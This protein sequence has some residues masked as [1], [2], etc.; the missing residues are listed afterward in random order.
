[1]NKSHFNRAFLLLLLIGITALFVK[2]IRPFL[3]AIFL[4]AIFAGLSAPLYRRILRLFRGRRALT[5]LATLLLLLLL[6]IIP[7]SALLGV[8]ANEAFHIAER[9][10]PWVTEQLQNPDHL[11]TRLEGIPGVRYLE[12]YRAQLLEKAGALVGTAGTFLFNGLSA[13][14]RG[15]VSFFFKFFI[16]LY[17]MFYFLMDGRSLLEKILRYVPMEEVDKQRMVD[18]FASVTR[19]TIKGTLLIGVT[20]GALSGL[21]FRIVGIDGAVFW[22]AV[23]TVLTIVP[24]IGTALVWL[25]AAIILLATGKTWQAI[26]LAGFCGLVVGNVDNLLRPRLV[27]HDTQMHSLLI[28]FGTTGG[29]MLFGV[30]GF[31]V[32]PIVAA[33]FVTIWEIYGEVFRDLLPGREP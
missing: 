18:K 23:M 17:T 4:A 6:V 10:R 30:L 9:V 20:Q 26:F 3:M 14:T 31:I 16:M 13:T 1:M 22:G 2:M 11:L 28:L 29:I 21:A 12:P 25:P 7:F 8:I 32:G 19:A 27:G 33:L 5:S 24:G 15:T